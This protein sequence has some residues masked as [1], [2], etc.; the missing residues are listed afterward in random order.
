[1]RERPRFRRAAVSGILSAHPDDPVK[2]AHL[3]ILA[4]LSAFVFNPA[5]AA[6][7]SV[8]APAV[9]A[10]KAKPVVV[11]TTAGVKTSLAKRAIA[12][13]RTVAG[14]RVSERVEVV[15]QLAR[16]G[17]RVQMNVKF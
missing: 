9:H 4:L 7:E 14:G 13:V 8:A 5:R 15:P 3:L 10:V 2:I 17:A 16:G 11:R 6:T 12:I 1:M